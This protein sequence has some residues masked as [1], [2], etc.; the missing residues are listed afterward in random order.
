MFYTLAIEEEKMLDK[1]NLVVD[2]APAAQV[3]QKD[4]PLKNICSYIW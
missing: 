3:G 2:L 1:I 4:V